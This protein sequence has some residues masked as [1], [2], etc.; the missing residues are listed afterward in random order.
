MFRMAE[1]NSIV[2]WNWYDT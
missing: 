2:L 1:Q